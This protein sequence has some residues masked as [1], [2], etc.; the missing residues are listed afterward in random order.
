MIG[1][2]KEPTGDEVT[3]EKQK[4]EG[5]VEPFKCQVGIGTEIETWHFRNALFED[6]RCVTRENI[7]I[8]MDTG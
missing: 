3:T 5:Q 4:M 8:L 2:R 6:I 7:Y 1:R